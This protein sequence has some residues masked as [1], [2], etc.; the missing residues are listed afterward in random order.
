M[1]NV[2]IALLVSV[3]MMGCTGTKQRVKLDAA[4]AE[5]VKSLDVGVAAG[6]L[7]PAK[8]LALKGEINKG[9]LSLADIEKQ[10]AAAKA[11]YDAAKK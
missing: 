8:G 5:I 1:R 7:D 2:I 3:L 11:A 4:V 10:I 9:Y 6:Y